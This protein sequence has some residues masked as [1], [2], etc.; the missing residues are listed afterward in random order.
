MIRLPAAA[1]LAGSI[2]LVLVTNASEPVIVLVGVAGSLGLGGLLGHSFTLI[3]QSAGLILVAYSLAVVMAAPAPDAAVISA[4]I[5]VGLTLLLVTGEAATRQ[6]GAPMDARVFGPWLRDV[7]GIALL[8]GIV[9]IVIGAAG[10]GVALDLPSWGYPLV[11]GAAGLAAVVG[12]GR[13]LIEYVRDSP[14]GRGGG[15]P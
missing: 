1:A 10:S 6:R 4:V 2:A 12:L 14:G 5:G 9:A 8:A 13:A 3:G 15:L 7:T 11:A